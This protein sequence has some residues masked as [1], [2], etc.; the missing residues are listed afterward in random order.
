MVRPVTFGLQPPRPPG[1]Y[2]SILGHLDLFLDLFFELFS[3]SF[4]NLHFFSS[5]LNARFFS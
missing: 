4:L 3:P 1:H 5:Q 2:L